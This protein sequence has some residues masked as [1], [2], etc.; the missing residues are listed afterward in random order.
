MY[1]FISFY[2]SRV[3]ADH[4]QE[5]QNN[6]GGLGTGLN[7]QDPT[8]QKQSLDTKCEYCLVDRLHCKK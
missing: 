1:Q 6:A 5:E 2:L 7:D 8:F 4:G 3:G